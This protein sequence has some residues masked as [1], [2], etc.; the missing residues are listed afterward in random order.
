MGPVQSAI[1]E[2]LTEALKPTFLDVEN[3]SHNHCRGENRETH[4]KITAVSDSF[5]SLASVRRHQV[6]YELLAQ[7]M[8]EGVHS[9]ALHL[10]TPAQWLSRDQVVPTSPKCTGH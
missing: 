9:L 1:Q 4:F 7:E 2:R 3:E 5:E 6:V 10:F 8:S